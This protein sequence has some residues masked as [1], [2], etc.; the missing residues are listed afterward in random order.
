MINKV[1]SSV[2]E[3]LHD[4]RDGMS[5]MIGGFGGAGTPYNLVKGLVE[6]GVEGLTIIANSFNNVTP[7]MK[8]G[9]QV[10]KVVMSFPV[11]PYQWSMHNP[12]KE[13]IQSGEIEVEIVP[14]GTLA[15]IIWAGGAGIP[16]LYTPTG[17]GTITERGKEKKIVNGVE[18]IM[19]K[20][21]KADFAF[22]KAYKGDSKGNLIYRMA[23]R[24]FNPV[25]A[26]AARVTVAEVESLVEA[27]EI[28]PDIVVTPGIFVDR[29][30]QAAPMKVIDFKERVRK[31][32]EI[33]QARRR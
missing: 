14:Q 12:F 3:T 23:M 9:S 10:K 21:L 16:A 31:Q 33:L 7:I 28:N 19:E 8:D 15:T 6:T 4:L 13:G 25:M 5:I 22:I 11:S 18:C 29:V 24:N 30:V 20:S 32:A 26:M 17:I 27:G 2:R 1:Y